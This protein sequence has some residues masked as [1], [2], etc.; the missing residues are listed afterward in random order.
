MSLITWSEK[1]EVGIEKIDEQH[2]S[3]FK[4]LNELESA[5]QKGKASQTINDIID[6]MINYTV[7]HFK[8][9]E[10]WFAKYRFPGSD[11]HIA[12]HK[13][14]LGDVGDFAK[15]L[16]AGEV[17]LSIDVIQFLSDW[18]TN[19]IM[20]IDMRYAPFMKFYLKQEAA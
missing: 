19:H 10:D 20:G 6:Q 9:E 15:K 16:N 7:E 3:L 2:E 17:G 1:Y 18:I 11:A 13:K 14:F 12:E 5:L 8:T 4:M